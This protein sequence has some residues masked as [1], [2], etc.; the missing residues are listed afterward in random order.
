MINLKCSNA[1][2][3]KDIKGMG[4][5]VK[6]KKVFRSE[7]YKGLKYENMIKINSKRV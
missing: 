5:I 2:A 1:G 3:R 6:L 4:I 7:I